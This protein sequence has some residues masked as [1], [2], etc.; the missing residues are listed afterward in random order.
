MTRDIFSFTVSEVASAQ[1]FM[2]DVNNVKYGDMECRRDYIVI[3]GRTC[4]N[5]EFEILFKE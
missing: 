3:P 2:L 5:L 4:F 1:N